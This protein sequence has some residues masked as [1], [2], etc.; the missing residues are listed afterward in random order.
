C[1][2]T[3]IALTGH[4]AGTLTI[5][6][7]NLPLGG[8]GSL[9]FILLMI[10]AI[11]KG[12]SMPF[13]S[14][15]PDAAQDAPLPFMALVPASLEKLLGIYL[16]TR[17]SLDMF[18]LNPGS[19]I[20]VMLMIIGAATILLAVMMALVQKEYK[21]LLSYH[22]ISQVGYMI[23]GI[24]T[25]LPAGIV[26]GL[27]HMLNNALYKS[28]LFLT[29]GSVEKQTGTTKLE[30]L[31]GIGKKMPITVGCFLIAAVSISGVPPFNGFFS[32]ELI[33]DGALE[34]GMVF[35]IAAALGSFFTAASFLKLGHAA[36]FGKL[37]EKHKGIKEVHFAMLFPMLTIA[38][39]CI[40]F[41]VCNFIPLRHLI[42]PVLSGQRWEGLDFSGA[43]TNI[44]LVLITLVI[45]IAAI[46][47]HIFGVRTTRSAVKAADHI[48]YAPV[49]SWIYDRAEKRFFD[50]YDIGNK[51]ARVIAEVAF[52]CDRKIDWLYNVLSLKLASISGEQI[53]RLHNGSYSTYLAWS[54]LG[55]GALIV[56][57]MYG[58]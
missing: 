13:H 15:I 30:E 46:L 43:P 58:A 1:M 57:L 27:F 55:F 33:Y 16:L 8:L 35:Y 40:L 36:F 28:C 17:I 11:S 4:L 20:S 50:P 45:L 21:R 56:F 31:G 25:C 2:M 29:G 19:W 47:N 37:N 26:G 41:G 38:F 54:L 32:K 9:A 51:A 52:W 39:L 22:A 49:L 6:R 5:S 44:K 34:R 14:W 10:G 24:G 23:L 42:Q 3:G 7:I 12:G 48:H 53:R 18:R